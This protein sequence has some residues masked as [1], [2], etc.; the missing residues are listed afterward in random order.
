MGPAVS[1]PIRRTHPKQCELTT[2]DVLQMDAAAA[3]A[4]AD[5]LVV[6][7]GPA[8]TGKTTMLAA[9]AN[10]LARCDD[11]CSALR[12]QP[13]LRTS[14]L[15]KRDF[16]GTRSP[17]C[18]TSGTRVID[19]PAC[20]TSC[21]QGHIIVDEAGRRSSSTRPA[22]S[23]PA[24]CA[25]SSTS[26]IA[27]PG[28]WFSS[29]TTRQLQAVG[30]GGMF[31]ELCRASRTYELARIHRFSNAWEADASLQLRAGQ[32]TALNAY[33]DHDRVVPARSMRTCLDR[34]A[35]GDP[36]Q[37]RGDGG[38]DGVPHAHVGTLN[39]AIQPTP[40]TIA[41]SSSTT[42]GHRRR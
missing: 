41:V 27:S 14:R 6:V 24:C 2:F 34:R 19:R 11:R 37:R 16:R 36:D 10:D 32:A 28:G 31:A 13:R 22:W 20:A 39:A 26:Q 42:P 17:S 38:G 9:A 29:V 3:D 18:S 7:V 12:R 8:A 21:R 40:G 1:K 30:R 33:V 15:T 4:G 25:G 5:R 23:A 35:V